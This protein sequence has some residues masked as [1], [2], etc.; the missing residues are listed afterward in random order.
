MSTAPDR[1]P[2]RYRL[3]VDESGDHAFNRLDEVSHRY[4]ALLGLWCRQQDHYI[5]LHD[6]LDAMRRK[7]FGPRLD[8]PVILH[9]EDILNRR[10]D[11]YVLQDDAR[12]AAFDQALLDWVRKPEYQIVCIVIDKQQHHDKY[13]SPMHP[14]HYCLTA[15]MQRYG[16][17]LNYKNA[18]GD[19]LAEARGKK[20]DQQLENA[21]AN[22]Y[23]SGTLYL[24]AATVQ[25]VLT[26][27]SLKL[28]SK[29][30]DIA[31]LQLADILA[32]PVKQWILWQKGVIPEPKGYGRELA[33]VAR[34]KFNVRH[35]TGQVEGYGWKLL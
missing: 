8:D 29:A 15:L 30:A 1:K 16:G 28:R 11:F 24:D 5:E 32:H 23:A 2:D 18:V 27:K 25:R 14:Y 17:W 12:R 33:E 4:L 20:E 35:D 13:S 31:G 34:T 10:G 19:V 6:G 7:F 9:R 21:Y 26:S 22:L 3:Y